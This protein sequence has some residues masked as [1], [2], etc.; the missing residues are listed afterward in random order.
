LSKI[1]KEKKAKPGKNTFI[2][3]KN[4]AKSPKPGLCTEA[5]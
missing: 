1:V 3:E 2:K 5:G 4:R